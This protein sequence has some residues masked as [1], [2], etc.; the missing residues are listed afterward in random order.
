MTNLAIGSNNIKVLKKFVNIGPIVDMC[1]ADTEQ[2]GQNDIFT[3]S[4]MYYSNFQRFCT[5]YFIIY[6][7]MQIITFNFVRF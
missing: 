2:R 5:I 6:I 3:C 1:I 7:L 4:G